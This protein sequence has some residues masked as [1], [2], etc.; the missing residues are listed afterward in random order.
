M[1][2][3]PVEIMEDYGKV[4][5]KQNCCSERKI[6]IENDVE[7][8]KNFILPFKFR[9]SVPIQNMRA[10]VN[11]DAK[12][13]VS[14]Y[15]WVTARCNIQCPICY[16][17]ENI[18]LPDPILDDFKILLKRNPSKEILLNGGEP[19][20]RD[21]LVDIIKLIKSCGKE[22]TIITN[23][24]KL[25]NKKYLKE[26][27]DAGLTNVY[28]SFDGFD[29][30][31]YKLLRGK[32]LLDDK[33]KALSNLKEEKV[34]TYLASVVEKNT[35]FDQIPKILDYAVLNN[36]FIDRIWFSC[37][38]PSTTT[39]SDIYKE[40]I[41]YLNVSMK[42]FYEWKRLYFNTFK[43][44]GKFFGKDLQQKFTEFTR[45]AFLFDTKDG[46]F[47][48]IYIKEYKKM[49]KLI[50]SYILRKS[51]LSPL[52]FRKVRVMRICVG[53]I[54]TPDNIDLCRRLVWTDGIVKL[55]KPIAGD[56]G[57]FEPLRL[58][59]HLTPQ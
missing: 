26:L 43:S 45:T 51:N 7:F 23:G 1:H 29:R 8:Y 57:L 24:L 15:F 17:A 12:S 20:V 37:L 48:P 22:V 3:T 47:N 19:T 59:L 54:V 10:L 46:E 21:D 16:Q 30:K 13:R 33:L 18:S 32:D 6:L 44:I 34:M 5:M 28:I 41:K 27:I 39:C 2:T 35:N 31:T 55:K 38:Y 25:K 14:T 50:I 36:D 42:Y 40:L 49:I 53:G 56:G 52:Q 58:P 9:D 4:F 11:G